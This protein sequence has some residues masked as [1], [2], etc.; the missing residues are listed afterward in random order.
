MDIQIDVNEVA[1]VMQEMFP[2]EYTIAVQR[3]HIKNLEKL[4]EDS[5][6]PDPEPVQ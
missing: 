4:V 2:K 5:Q 6:S 3:V 1:A